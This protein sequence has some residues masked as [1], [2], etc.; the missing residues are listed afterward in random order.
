MS[1]LAEIAATAIDEVPHRL[2][3]RVTPDTSLIEVVSQLREHR[4]GAV[5]VE[6]ETGI[7]GIFTERDVMKR[8]D[9]TD[10]AWHTMKVSEVMTASPKTIRTNQTISDAINAMMVGMF[11]HLPMVDADGKPAGIVSIRDILMHIVEFFPKE[12][13]N[14]PPD[15]EHEA[16]APWGG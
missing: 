9:H 12:F 16:N 4:R 2:A 11:R 7:V 3:V 6:D 14:L 8:I 10:Q 13:V 1:T 5:I 15:P